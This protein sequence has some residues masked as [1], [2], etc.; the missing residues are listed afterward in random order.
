MEFICDPF[1]G[2]SLELLINIYLKESLTN[3]VPM[4]NFNDISTDL[5]NDRI[6]IMEHSLTDRTV[7]K[8]CQ[9]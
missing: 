8:L 3:E 7:L 5:I 6:R 2:F 1:R 9:G 4:R